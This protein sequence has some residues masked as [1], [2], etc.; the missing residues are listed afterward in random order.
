V[1]G[2]LGVFYRVRTLGFF[3]SVGYLTGELP[4]LTRLA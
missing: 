2:D 4:G 3:I 1:S